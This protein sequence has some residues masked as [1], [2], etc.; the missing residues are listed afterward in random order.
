MYYTRTWLKWHKTARAVRALYKNWSQKCMLI[1][2]KSLG[3]IKS[4]VD[5]DSAGI[6]SGKTSP[7]IN[8]TLAVLKVS[9]EIL[10]LSC[11]EPRKLNKCKDF[12]Q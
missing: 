8:P 12:W 10:G 5:S 4:H 11:S 1:A 3:T 7:C 6:A 9:T 2:E